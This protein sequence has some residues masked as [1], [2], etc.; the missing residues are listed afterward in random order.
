MNSE[1]ELYVTDFFILADSTAQLSQIITD[2]EKYHIRLININKNIAVDSTYLASFNQ[3]LDII[4][5]FE[6]NLI[7]YKTKHGMSKA[8]QNGKAIGR[9]KRTDENMQ[10]AIEMYLSK[11][12]TLDQIKEETSISRSTLYRHLAR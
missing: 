11:H 2:F 9:P 3:M 7:R 1:D 5:D 10:R 4:V 6:R 8:A 12:Y